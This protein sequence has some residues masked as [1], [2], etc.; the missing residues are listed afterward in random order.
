MFV[1]VS[2]GV[3]C[4]AWFVAASSWPQRGWSA[5]RIC[6]TGHATAGATGGRAT[7][8]INSSHRPCSATPDA[9]ALL[10]GR[11]LLEAVRPLI[12]R[13][14]GDRVAVLEMEMEMEWK[15][16]QDIVIILLLLDYSAATAKTKTKKKKQAIDVHKNMQLKQ[17]K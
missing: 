5:H 10:R 6:I 3:M 4:D 17:V 15:S 2:G 7:Q 1:V 8:A 9:S 12:G 16:E 11:R 13:P 14:R